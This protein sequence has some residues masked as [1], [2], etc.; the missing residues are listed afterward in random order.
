MKLVRK[1]IRL[2]PI[3]YLLVIY[4]ILIFGK[5][6]WE[7]IGEYATLSQR[8]QKVLEALDVSESS[9]SYFLVDFVD[10]LTGPFSDIL[11]W[12]HEKIG[13]FGYF[14]DATF[15]ICCYELWCSLMFLLFDVFGF[16]FNVAE[17]WLRKGDK[18]NE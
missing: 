3:I 9:W 14:I 17:A 4:A 6:I 8:I 16:I 10:P 1:F 5:G 12:I 15:A 2:L 7:N 18:M 11:T 13:A